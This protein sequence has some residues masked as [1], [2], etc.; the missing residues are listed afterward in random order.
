MNNYVTPFNIYYGT[1]GKTL[2]CKYRFTKNFRNEEDAKKF[3]KEVASSFFY[4]NEGKYGLPCYKDI[5]KESEITG[6]TIEALYEDHINDMMRWYTIPTEY[7]SITSK[8]LRW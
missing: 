4:K 7:D 3:A 2:G 5:M 1:I 6:L 8:D